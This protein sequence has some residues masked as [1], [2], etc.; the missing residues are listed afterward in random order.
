MSL[1]IKSVALKFLSQFRR[2][3]LFGVST[4]TH[5]RALSKSLVPNLLV[6]APCGL[7]SSV[8]AVSL[9]G[10]IHLLKS[11]RC[12]APLRATVFPDLF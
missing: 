7:D 1:F 9:A 4:V 3:T 6:V 8:A 5:G 12:G 10:L 2:Q 11:L